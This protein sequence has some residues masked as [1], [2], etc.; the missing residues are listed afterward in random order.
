MNFTFIPYASAKTY[1][2]WVLLCIICI[3]GYLYQNQVQQCGAS[4]CYLISYFFA[5]RFEFTVIFKIPYFPL[6]GLILEQKQPHGENEPVA[7]RGETDTSFE[8]RPHLKFHGDALHGI[9]KTL[10][11]QINEQTD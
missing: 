4:N 11:K 8:E 10:D 9:N 6:N 3:Y 1:E 5:W 2:T 7:T